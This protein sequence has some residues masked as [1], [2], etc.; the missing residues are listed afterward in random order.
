M[1]QRNGRIGSPGLGGIFAANSG[2][3]QAARYTIL[4]AVLV[5]NS[6]PPASVSGS[7]L[8]LDTTEYTADQGILRRGESKSSSKCLAL[9]CERKAWRLR[10]SSRPLREEQQA[11][12]AFVRAAQAS[13]EKWGFPSGAGQQGI[14][15]LPPEDCTLGQ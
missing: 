2:R 8:D 4:A 9:A 7:L 6:F 12:L 3:T 13:T 1:C 14:P 15:E 5:R 10:C 11:I